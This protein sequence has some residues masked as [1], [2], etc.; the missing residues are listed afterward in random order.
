MKTKSTS[1]SAF[2]NLR[3][4]IG[5]FVFVAGVFLALLGFGAFSNASAQIKG[6]SGAPG[7]TVNPMPPSGSVQEEW[8]ARY[9]GPG[10]SNDESHA[11][12]VDGSGNVLCGGIQSQTLTMIEFSN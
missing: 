10:N 3:V 8:V 9:D 2:L 1:R 5:L 12:A 4:L 6:P 7:R 11:I